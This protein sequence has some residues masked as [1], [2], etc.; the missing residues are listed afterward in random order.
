VQCFQRDE[1]REFNGKKQRQTQGV[2][3]RSGCILFLPEEV[4]LIFWLFAGISQWMPP[5]QWGKDW[6]GSSVGRAED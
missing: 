2:T 5:S 6:L 4:F 3:A 1:F